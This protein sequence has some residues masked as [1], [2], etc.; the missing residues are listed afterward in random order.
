MRPHKAVRTSFQCFGTAKSFIRFALEQP[1]QMRSCQPPTTTEFL[2]FTPPE[3]I[4]HHRTHP[5]P[6]RTAGIFKPTSIAT[7]NN[8]FTKQKQQTY[9]KQ[10]TNNHQPNKQR[11]KQ[12]RSNKN[13]NHAAGKR[14]ED[15]HFCLIKEQTKSEPRQKILLKKKKKQSPG[16]PSCLFISRRC[17]PRLHQQPHGFAT[18]KSARVRGP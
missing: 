9:N 7:D 5:R 14:T 1:T 3:M 2:I 16:H 13:N 4:K 6:I 18:A 10:R 11:Q 17:E 15:N 12:R 8:N